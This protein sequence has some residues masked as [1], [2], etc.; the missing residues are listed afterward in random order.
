MTFYITTP[1]Y[2]ANDV[3]HL[4]HAYTTVAADALARFHRARGEKVW[5][6]TGT[7]EHGQKIEEAAQRRGKT[8]MQHLDD[9]VP[10]FQDTWRRLNISH[11]DFIRTT[12]ERHQKVVHDI[13]RAM[14]A[15]GDIELGAYEGLYCVAC[16][17][18]YT[19][20]Q[21]APGNLCPTHQRK[22]E[23]IKEPSYFFK[24]S[25]YQDQL[26]A[27]IEQHPGFIQ[28]DSAR[29]EIISFIKSG[30]RDLS[31][32]RT[33]FKWGIPVPDDPAHVTYVWVDA[34]TNYVSALGGPG[35]PAYA[36]FWDNP[37]ALSVHLLGKDIV[38]FHAVY[39]PCMLLSAGWA[40]PKVV[41]T[42]GWWTV[43][44]AKISK[45]LPATRVDPNL[46][47]ETIGTDALRYF[48]LREVPLGLDGDFSYEALIGRFNSDLANDLG[49]L[50][51]RSL[52][53]TEKYV[54]GVVPAPHPEFR[55]K[56]VHQELEALVVRAIAETEKHWGA[57][58]PSRAL[59]AT[60]ELVRGANRYIDAA[61]PWTL[62]KNKQNPEAL[63]ELEHVVHCMLEAT[64]VGALL[65]SPAMPGKLAEILVQ[66]GLPGLEL[67][68]PAAWNTNLPAG[69]RIGK[70]T[71][72]FPRIDE[73]RAGDLM[74]VWLKSADPEASSPPSPSPA[75]AEASS[76]VSYDD[77]SRLD[78]RVARIATAEKVPKADKLLKLTVELGPGET[79][80]VVAGIAKSFA[81]EAVI[82]RRV[83]FLANLKPAKI[84]GI[85]S[86]G[87]ILA[88]GDA[89]VL[90]LSTI[91]TDVPAGTK[92]R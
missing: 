14:R 46:L 2:Y 78:L 42:H 90:G 74:R 30:L 80:Q 83:I 70:P 13:W 22:V 76:Q 34:L 31:I 52:S 20:G 43:R 38:R 19:E 91:D 50:L 56:A 49:N 68:W 8:P 82:G 55:G 84:R 88:A 26:L 62:A 29:K 40:L 1:I 47:A 18:F 37:D 58:A 27:H 4:G 67:R 87:M 39:W 79:R 12:D 35:S 89:E 33:T 41:M 61:G 69:T 10:R 6:L 81:P 17:A 75:P 7:D 54:A 59:E 63:A 48:L 24:M 25:R 21:L 60:W 86:Q 36:T 3:P 9:V 92:V 85:E 77:F 23:L 64:L 66:L 53:M 73:A 72:I 51:N 32:S 16:E 5:F 57:L 45:S 28:P 15:R 11:D 44:G 71:P 65:A